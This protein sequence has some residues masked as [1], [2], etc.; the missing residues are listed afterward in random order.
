VPAVLKRND[1]QLEVNLSGLPRSEFQDS[2]EKVSAI[3]GRRF[4]F[5]RKLWI[6]PADPQIAERLL[7]TVRPECDQ[8]LLNWIT[9]AKA[10]YEESLTSPLPDDAE[11]LLVPWAYSRAPWQP[12]EVNENKVVGLLPYQRAAVKVMVD[13]KRAILADDMGLGKTL[14]AISAVE[15]YALRNGQIEGP[16]LVIAPASVVG[17]W[18]RELER[19][20]EEP[21][22]VVVKGSYSPRAATAEDRAA[23]GHTNARLTGA[24]VRTRI[25]QEAIESN[26]WVVINWEQLRVEKAKI[27]KNLRNGG[28]KTVTETRMKQPLFETTEWLAVIADEV[29]RAK[30]R[31]AAQTKGL[32]RVSGQVMLGATGT[33]IM[34]SPDELWAILRWLWPG[35]F[36]ELGARKNAQAYWGFYEAY[37]E[38]WEDHFGKKTVTG[39]KNPDALRFVLR[40][41]LIRRTAAILG[42]KGRNRIYYDVALNPKQ[43][44][45]YDE[46]ETAMWLAIEA[47]ITAGNKEALELAK[48]LDSASLLRLPNGAARVVRLQQIIENPKLL[49]GPDDSSIM[50]SF[51][52]KFLDS[53]PEPW[54]FYF[55]FKESCNIFAERL[56]SKFGANVGVYHGD[57]NPDERTKLEDAFQRGELDAL[58]GTIAAMGTGITLT[59]ARLSAFA[60][61]DWVPDINEQAEARLDRLGQQRQVLVYIPQALDTVATGKVEPTNRLKEVIVKTVLPKQSIEETTSGI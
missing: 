18:A 5:E 23:L 36:H 37:V 52:E 54:V 22:V 33:P 2:K 39:V 38:Y 11:G 1:D 57:V 9:E 31:D 7:K 61:R 47:D 32:W 53:R 35:E 4:D 51:E 27:K 15:E 55:K 56:R 21:N 40:D 6:L 14:Q 46:A 20:L 26:A 34:N 41:K 8:D 3:P 16:K 50:D 25:L 17:S 45:L 19:W 58:V 12:E 48:S 59:R 43:Q 13:R 10:G 30:N 60:S 24:E 28:T 29:H 42:L 49:G 44:K